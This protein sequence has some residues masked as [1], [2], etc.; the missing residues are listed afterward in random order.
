[1]TLHNETKSFRG[2]INAKEISSGDIDLIVSD[3]IPPRSWIKSIHIV[4]ESSTFQLF[5]HEVQAIISAVISNK[6]ELI[7]RDGITVILQC[8]T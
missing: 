7:I 6:P 2:T 1:M 3:D 8:I 4:N 5:D